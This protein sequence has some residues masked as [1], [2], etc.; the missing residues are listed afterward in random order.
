MITRL[1][2][3]I[4]LPEHRAAGFGLMVMADGEL[5]LHKYGIL[6]HKFCDNTTL[7]DINYEVENIRRDNV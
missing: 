2:D 4:L 6:L 7:Q 5:Q 1:L 3:G